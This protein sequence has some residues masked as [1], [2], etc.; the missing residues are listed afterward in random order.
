MDGDVYMRKL[1]IMLSEN[2][3]NVKWLVLL[4][5]ILIILPFIITGRF[6]QNMLILILMWTSLGTAWNILGGYT[7]Q[8]SL[9]NAIFFGIGGYSVAVLY[10]YWNVTPWLGIIIGISISILVSLLL[11]LPLFRLNAQYFAIAT[12]ALGEV[13]RILA[14]NWDLIG[15][16]GGISIL[17]PSANSLYAMQF[18]SK[19]PYYYLFLV[20]LVIVFVIML[21]INSSRMGYYF[22]AIKAN[23]TSAASIGIDTRKY[24]TLAFAISAIITSVCG[25]IYVEYQLF[26]APS[27]VFLNTVSM[28]MIMIA[29]FGGLGTIFG[30]ALGALILVPLSEY[31]RVKFATILPGI[32]QV[33]YGS[34]IIIMVL[35]QPKG[36]FQ[37]VKDVVNKIKMFYL[38]KYR[39]ERSV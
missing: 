32:D 25:S 19:V 26:V 23:E 24:K 4:F 21:Y 39:K 36:A 15:G 3:M 12:V 30:P 34:L 17:D 33:L 16:A 5:T 1:K 11:A 9:G 14:V 29:V 7:G 6:Q 10:T 18:N 31:T 35:F 22:R 8:V 28:Q 37:V 38:K 20:I 2:N 27:T 13:L